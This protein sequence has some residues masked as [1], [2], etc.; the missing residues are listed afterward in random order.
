MRQCYSSANFVCVQ[1]IL[2]ERRLKRPFAPRWLQ[3]FRRGEQFL[4]A[5]DHGSRFWKTSNVQSSSLRIAQA[6][7]VGRAVI[8]AQPMSAL[9]HSNQFEAQK[10]ASRFGWLLY[11]TEKDMY[12]I[13]GGCGF[14]KKLLHILSQITY[15]AAR[16]QQEAESPIIPMTANSLHD[17]L[18]Q[19]RQ[20]SPESKPWEAAQSGPAVIDWVRTQPEGF[21]I[22]TNAS[23]QG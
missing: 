12:E 4:E 8:L 16:L 5:T 10:E 6:I 14:S 17:V 2:I 11:G 18:L 9:P 13:H 3:G 19:M 21:E 15:C 23:M 22:D 1:I 7:I 20:W